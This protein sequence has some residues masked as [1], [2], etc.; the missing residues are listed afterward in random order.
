M[1]PHQTI[2]SWY[3]GRWWVGC[4]IWYSEE[5][6]GR[7][8]SPLR[9]LLAVPN[10]TAHHQ[11][12]VYQSPYCCI[13]VRCSVVLMCPLKGFNKNKYV[14]FVIITCLTAAKETS[15][16]LPIAAVALTLQHLTPW[17]HANVVVIR[18]N[19]LISESGG[20][21]PKLLASLGVK[22]G[23]SEFLGGVS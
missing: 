4:Y 21:D 6:T 10:V 11:R 13:T 9:P 8:R 15:R 7:G 14:T 20:S 1:L 5:G 12:P 19:A 18:G 22:N 17:Q 3:T 23:T 16:A 2:W